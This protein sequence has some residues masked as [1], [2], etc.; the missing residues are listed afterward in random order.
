MKIAVLVPC[1]RDPAYRFTISLIGLMVHVTKTRPDIELGS[2]WFQG[3]LVSHARNRLLDDA[4][5]WG[6]DF[7]L[8]LDADHTFP[9]DALDRL[10]AHNVEAVGINPAARTDPTGPTAANVLDGKLAP[11]WTTQEMKGLEK[12][13]RIGFGIALLNLSIMDRLKDGGPLFHFRLSDDGR[14]LTGEDYYFCERLEQ[15]GI[16]VYVD[17]ALSWEVGHIHERVL[18]PA[19]TEIA[20][21]IAKAG[22]LRGQ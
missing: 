20:R 21:I 22:K 6:A 12:V 3:S 1:F 15:A 16:P 2:F 10:L 13:D 9:M 18:F 17:H 11:V 4:I 5:N 8:F 14:E 7:A 19:D